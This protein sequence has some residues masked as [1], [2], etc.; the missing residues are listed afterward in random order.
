MR[1]VPEAYVLPSTRDGA[2]ELCPMSG[3]LWDEAAEAIWE[4]ETTLA[5]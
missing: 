2:A 4:L 5:L 3:V 1:C